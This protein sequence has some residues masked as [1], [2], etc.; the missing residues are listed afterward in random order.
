MR[1]TYIES[2]LPQTPSLRIVSATEHNAPLRPTLTTTWANMG[3]LFLPDHFQPEVSSLSDIKVASIAWGF[4][5]GFSLLTG[6]KAGAQT[7][8]IY[9]RVHRV[10]PYLALMWIEI[11]ANVRLHLYARIHRPYASQSNIF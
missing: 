7:V 11:L 5:L 10:T 8:R 4:Q 6:A 1:F 2:L 3:S 9:R